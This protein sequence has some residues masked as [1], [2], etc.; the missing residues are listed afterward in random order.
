M[1]CGNLRCRAEALL[2]LSWMIDQLKFARV[3]RDSR[4]IRPSIGEQL[5]SLFR[6]VFAFVGQGQQNFRERLQV[7]PFVHGELHLLHAAVAVA[8]DFIEPQ[9]SPLV[10]RACTR[11]R[12]C[13]R[14]MPRTRPSR[15]GRPPAILW[16]PRWP[17]SSGSNQRSVS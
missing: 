1:L 2:R 8:M 6:L 5:A 13:P 17:A 12:S 7:V 3:E 14:P 16:L 11:S 9:E 10:S 15:L 4:E